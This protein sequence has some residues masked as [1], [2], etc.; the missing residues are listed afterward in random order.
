MVFQGREFVDVTKAIV[1]GYTDKTG[2]DIVDKL[3]NRG[4]LNSM[5]STVGLVLAAAVFGAPIKAAGVA[6]AIF[7]EIRKF[8][9][10][11]TQLMILL[12]DYAS[13]FYTDSCYVLRHISG[14]GRDRRPGLRG[15]R[16][17]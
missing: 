2:I 3:L 1:S 12:H 17:A 15:I 9:K 7:R 11:P 4:G 10:T 8:A 14:N 16:A 13:D 6:E 5:L